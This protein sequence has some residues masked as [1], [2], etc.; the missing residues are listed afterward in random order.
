[1]LTKSAIEELKRI[2]GSERLLTDKEDLICYSYDATYFCASPDAVIIPQTREQVASILKIANEAG[3]PVIPRGAGTNLAGSSVP[4]EHGIVLSLNEL[5]KIK[6]IDAD[7]LTITVEAGVITGD[8]HKAVEQL[9]LFYPPDPS[10]LKISTIGGNV[11]TNAGGPRGVKY[12]VTRDYVIGMEMVLADGRILKIGGKTIKNVTGYDLTKF[13]VGSEGTLGVITEITLRLLP[14]PEQK[15]TILAIFDSLV[16][17]AKTVSAI[18]AA[19]IIPTTLE[20][21]DQETMILIEKFKPCGM[22]KDSQAAIIIE[23]DGD[24]T[25]VQKQMQKVIQVCYDNGAKEIL[26]AKTAQEAD[27]LWEGRRNAYSCIAMS[28]PTALVEDATVPRNKIP[29]MAEAITKIARKYELSIPVIGHAGDGNLHPTI[30]ANERDPNIMKKVEQAT[31]EI[32]QAAL[33]LGGTLSGEHGIGLAKMKFLEWEVGQVGL[34]V[35][36][37]L[38]LAVDPNNILNPGKIFLQK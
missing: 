13:F 17:G 21:I 12:G 10:S 8:I 9:G 28:T 35:M 14:L 22:P 37:N 38:K 31:E 2:V 16:A 5:N 15:K 18:L 29:E 11:A 19:K 26:E 23:I 34:E 27:K 32:F 36:R 4:I 7:N 25:E 3:I 30:C 33:K 20:L 6:E 24:E 1:M